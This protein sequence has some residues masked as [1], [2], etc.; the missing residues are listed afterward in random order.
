MERGGDE[1]L[2]YQPNA[3]ADAHEAQVDETKTARLRVDLTGFAGKLQ[4]EWTRALDGASQ[5]A[6]MI[7]GGTEREFVAPWQGQDV[8]L[9]LKR[10]ERPRVSA[11]AG[12]GAQKPATLVPGRA[13]ASA[14]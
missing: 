14:K 2:V 4:V 13:A 12:G 7:E 10:P 1:I 3:A 8:L 9:R 6:G 11:G 5:K